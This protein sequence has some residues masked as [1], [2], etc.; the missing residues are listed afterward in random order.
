MQTDSNTADGKP[1]AIQRATNDLLHQVLIALSDFDTFD[2]VCQYSLEAICRY[3]GW[4]LG[5]VLLRSKINKQT[6]QFV[7]SGIRYALLPSRSVDR[8]FDR[9]ENSEA[10]GHAAAFL[11]S[12]EQGIAIFE[13]ELFAHDDLLDQQYE[14]QSSRRVDAN[15]A[16][17][18]LGS[19][20]ILPIGVDDQ[21]EALLVFYGLDAV[22]PGAPLMTEL[23]VIGQQIGLMIA[24]SKQ[25]AQ[26]EERNKYLLQR[27]EEIE[28]LVFSISDDL[29][30][31]LASSYILLDHLRRGIKG[32][33]HPDRLLTLID[34]T[35]Q[36][37][38]RM[39]L[40]IQG[41]TDFSRLGWQHLQLQPVDLKTLIE[42][43]LL[44]MTLLCTK[45]QADV[46]IETK[47]PT[48]T[49][50]PLA[51]SQVIDN[52]IT[53][54]F[55]YASKA[56][57]TLKVRI[58]ACQYNNCW[59]IY[60]RDNGP[61]ISSE[62]LEKIFTLFYRIPTEPFPSEPFPSELLLSVPTAEDLYPTIGKINDQPGNS[63]SPAEKTAVREVDLNLA[64]TTR[65]QAE[66]RKGHQVEDSTGIGLAI[67]QRIVN[68]LKGDVW[69]DST[70]GFGTTFWL[71]MP[72]SEDADLHP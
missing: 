43:I 61:G 70:P 54:A 37:S 53:N 46:R 34:Q 57:R 19:C 56:N 24:R 10:I 44:D 64:D 66:H 2:T 16:L 8:I 28:E 39:A 12:W 21:I 62:H 59:H 18:G 22:S 51:I 58:G 23:T 38:Q 49:T 14:N 47:L 5:H 26:L 3:T 30:T 60:V 52:L 27:N 15:N 71:T 13:S 50:D 67:V 41:L 69:A 29:K 1:L 42:K 68:R 72:N 9:I 36:S 48:I 45:Y 25:V 6:S 11:K 31:P 33:E 63:R 4:P 65:N 7:A 20:L 40:L 35:E 32:G 17:A 55:K